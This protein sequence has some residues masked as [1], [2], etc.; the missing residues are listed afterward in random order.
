VRVLVH[1][2]HRVPDRQPITVRRDERVH[3]GERS[4]DWPAFVFVA[5]DSG[6]GWVPERHLDGERP[7]ATVLTPYDTRELDAPAG[8]TLTLVRDD[9]SSGWA[10]C[11]DEAGNEG[12]VPHRVFCRA[13]G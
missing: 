3:V 7:I 13:S 11:R 6:Q 12:W 5:G 4:P 8:A 1:T 10:W 9:P 2:T